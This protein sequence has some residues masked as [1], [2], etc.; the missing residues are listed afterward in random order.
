MSTLSLRGLADVIGVDDKA[1]RKAEKAGVF[2]AHI[3]RGDDGTVLFMDVAGCIEA[4]RK[5]GRQLRKAKPRDAEV[6]PPPPAAA[7]VASEVDDASDTGD[8][9]EPPLDAGAAKPDTYVEAQKA[10]M[11]ERER[12]LRMQNDERAGQLIDVSR[13]EK[14]AYEF[15]RTLRDNILNVPAR[16]AAELAAESSATRVHLRLDGA[17]REALE[18]VGTVI[19]AGSDTTP[20]A[21]EG[22]AR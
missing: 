6:P 9:D 19:A 22:D 1:V 14:L 16:I 11:R 7:P 21:E 13:A 4:W 15:A 5:S 3:R 10:V 2:G 8:G 12:M 18:S 17:L 20:A